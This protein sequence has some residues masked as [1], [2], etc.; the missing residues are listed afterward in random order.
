MWNTLIKIAS[1]ILGLRRMAVQGDGS[2]FVLLGWI[3][4][5]RPSLR[6]LGS[7]VILRRT[8]V[9]GRHLCGMSGHMTRLGVTGMF[10][11]TKASHPRSNGGG[12]LFGLDRCGHLTWTR[13]F[14]PIGSSWKGYGFMVCVR[15]LDLLTEGLV[16]LSPQVICELVRDGISGR[17][18]IYQ[19]GSKLCQL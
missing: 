13:W 3:R 5:P 4:K 18:L 15:L 14:V 10:L 2:I 9:P 19:G 11:N 1:G 17:H 8:L 7:F 12:V 16:M 6:M